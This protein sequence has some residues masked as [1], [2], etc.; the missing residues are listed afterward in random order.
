MDFLPGFDS[1][2]RPAC[3]FIL[4][5]TGRK[6]VSGG[7]AVWQNDSGWNT[8]TAKRRQQE[9]RVVMRLSPE[10]RVIFWQQYLMTEKPRKAEISY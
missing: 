2:L 1:I 6:F 4:E 8:R 10:I 3:L 7:A 5:R 9:S